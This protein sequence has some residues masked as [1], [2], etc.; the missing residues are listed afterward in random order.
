MTGLDPEKD[1]VLEV[2][3]LRSVGTKVT[4]ELCTLLSFDEPTKVPTSVHGIDSGMLREAPSFAAMASR[5][6]TCLQ[7]AVLVAHGGKLDMRFLR[8]EFARL[9]RD[10]RC[11]RYV[12]T[13]HLGRQ[14]CD[15]PSHRLEA[16]AAHLETQ[17]RP[18]HRAGPDAWATRD[19][20]EALLVKSGAP[21][22][23]QLWQLQRGKGP[24]RAEVFERAE[25]ALRSGRRV[26]IRYR[27][28]KRGKRTVEFVV[29]AVQ[30]ELDPPLVL[31]YLHDSRGALTLRA[32][33]IL[34]IEPSGDP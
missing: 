10:W 13:L 21:T 4:S 18:K 6:W 2:C 20:F 34:A 17:H 11:V 30:R 15:L 16:L 8:M 28:A 27:S 5:L 33:R 19:V 3:L 22:C 23:E 7:G 14:L 32:D 31:G 29:T 25:E 26:R 24:A 1:R 9:G 12:D